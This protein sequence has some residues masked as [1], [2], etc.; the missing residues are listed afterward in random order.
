MKL[1]HFT[2]KTGAKRVLASGFQNGAGGGCWLA[3][4]GAVWTICGQ[5]SRQTL[6]EVT[7]NLTREQLTPYRRKFREKTLDALTGEP[8]PDPLGERCGPTVWYHIPAKVLNPE[9]TKIRQVTPEE[10]KR[11]AEGTF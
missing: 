10:R 1:Y 6:L 5:K 8:I 2:T 4:A 11:L 9:I 3:E 7:L